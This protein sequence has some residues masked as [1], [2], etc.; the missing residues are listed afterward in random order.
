MARQSAS[1]AVTP[2]PS[3]GSTPLEIFPQLW[4]PQNLALQLVKVLNIV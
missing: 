2:I 4:A 1:E 3:R